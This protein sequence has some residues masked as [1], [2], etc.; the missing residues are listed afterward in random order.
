MSAP[1]VT[2]PRCSRNLN[3]VGAAQFRLCASVCYAFVKKLAGGTQP[4]YNLRIAHKEDAPSWA[5]EESV[6]RS[7]KPNT[8]DRNAS[9]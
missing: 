3:R 8:P 2:R 4:K 5:D 9:W 7:T 1:D 6:A